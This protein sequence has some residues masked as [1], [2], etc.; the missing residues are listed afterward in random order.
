MTIPE[1]GEL[2]MHYKGMYYKI[3]QLGFIE[4]T[5][6][7]CVIYQAQYDDIELG[8]KPVFVRPLKA[9]IEEVE[10]EERIV[11]RFQKIIV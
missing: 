2:Y 9:F 3:L 1:A 10:V 4:S 11:P 8:K 6:E 5:L 7:P